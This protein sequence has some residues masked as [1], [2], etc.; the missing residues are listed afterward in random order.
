MGFTYNYK[1]KQTS[2]I[3][4]RGVRDVDASQHNKT[5]ITAKGREV[6]KLSNKK[7]IR[8][9]T[10]DL[11][12]VVREGSNQTSQR[13]VIHSLGATN[14]LVYLPVTPL[15]LAEHKA[16]SQMLDAVSGQIHS[17]AC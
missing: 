5:K 7:K 14:V 17:N 4:T 2:I 1:I 6:Q 13:R 12:M 15:K 8:R 9:S 16:E 11:V 3:K 10:I